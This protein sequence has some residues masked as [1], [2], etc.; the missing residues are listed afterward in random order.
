[1]SH[2]NAS[3]IHVLA[4][5]ANSVGNGWHTCSFCLGTILLVG[6]IRKKYRPGLMFVWR[7]TACG[8]AVI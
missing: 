1:M 6:V 5:R 8:A 3:A 4:T 7:E 2:V